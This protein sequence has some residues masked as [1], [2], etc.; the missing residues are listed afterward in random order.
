LAKHDS[1]RAGNVCRDFF[2]DRPRDGQYPAAFHAPT[3]WFDAN[4]LRW[5]GRELQRRS[6]EN[7]LRGKETFEADGN[8]CS[9]R[10]VDGDLYQLLSLLRFLQIFRFYLNAQCLY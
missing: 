1:L 5:E 8:P 10:S 7:F 4:S 6:Q 9:L 3:Q 2:K